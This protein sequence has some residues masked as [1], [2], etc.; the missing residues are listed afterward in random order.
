MMQEEGEFV[1][2]SSFH[3]CISIFSLRILQLKPYT[4]PQD[5]HPQLSVHTEVGPATATLLFL[6][7]QTEVCHPSHHILIF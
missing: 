5:S 2:L 4:P 1:I 3:N 7:L 6:P